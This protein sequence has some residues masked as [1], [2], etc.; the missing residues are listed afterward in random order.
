[1]RIILTLLA[2]LFA[3]AIGV[4]L[5]GQARETAH[6]DAIAESLIGHASE[7][8]TGFVDFSALQ[9]LPPPVARY[10]RFA[11]TDGQP[12]IRK[13]RFRQSGVLRTATTSET[14]LS[15]TADHLIVPPA[16]GFLWN[17]RV[18]LPVAMHIRVL[19]G[20]VAG[21][22][23]GRVS[24]LSAF[25]VSTESGLPE[26]DAGALHRYLAEAV[27]APTALLP[28]SGVAW[29]PID[30]RSALATLSDRGTTVSLEFRF[31]DDGAVT[32]IYTPARFGH[33]DGAY[34]EAPWE[35]HFRDYF[36]RSGMRV[37][38]HGEV[39]WHDNGDLKLVWEG[40]VIDAHYEFAR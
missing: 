29:S 5:V 8:A 4:L 34:R 22:G 13:A 31:G 36:L 32:G 24:F 40:T 27:W 3:G 26:L 10:F 25:A 37:P 39:G 11:L 28:Q 35:G 14:W 17:A 30:E 2:L 38:R 12:M 9:Q 23:S 33:F 18:V 15:F 19:D 7:P 1:M 21:A 16:P 20:Y 6:A